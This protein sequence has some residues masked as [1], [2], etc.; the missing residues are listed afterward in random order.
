MIALLIVPL[1][2]VSLFILIVSFAHLLYRESLRLRARDLPSM[3]YFRETLEERIGLDPEDGALAF[4]L[5]RHTALLALTLVWFAIT[6]RGNAPLW[7]EVLE[8]GV[9]AWLTMMVAAYIA[10][11]F[12]YR[13]TS[14]RWA[15]ALLP[16]LR[17]L[18]IVVKPVLSFLAFLQSVADLSEKNPVHSEEATPEEHI[19]ALIDAGAEEGIFEE[20]DRKLIQSVVAFGDKRVR[21]VMTPRPAIV[22][23]EEEKS[24][25]EARTL[26]I[27]EQYS[28]LPVY[29]DSIDNIVGFLHA[30]DIFELDYDTRASMTVRDVMREIGAV[31]ETKPVS[32]LM[33]EMQ[34]N[35][36]HMVVVVD[37]YGNTAGL[38][39]ME[40][41][42][43]EI[44]G[45]IRDEHE[46]SHDV[47]KEADGSFV[48]SGSFDLDHL[49]ELVD[50]RPD[51]ETEASTV[52]G[53]VTEWLGH[54]P[55]AGES[56]E[57]EGIRLVVLAA[58]E[59]KVERV[60]LSKI[61][62]EAPSGA[63][64]QSNGR[65]R[66]GKNGPKAR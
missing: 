5:I 60:R 39:T 55:V 22:A 47:D 8:A 45:E 66:N 65:A 12:L 33:R 30:R 40:D 44:V 21:E 37:E 50:F 3:E 58:N 63:P 20:E 36:R 53:L 28:R 26:L 38:A 13:R 10:P 62:E 6:L 17:V 4:S 27:N 41:L 51:E 9:L 35:G 61:V 11:Q 43:E 64:P 1:A 57:R 19:D 2:V 29:E 54:V 42:V 34:A 56:V 16:L 32:D 14:G 48:V 24:L 18:A 52:G 59:L 7:Q 23:I 46:P 15:Y 25:E 31:P 49:S